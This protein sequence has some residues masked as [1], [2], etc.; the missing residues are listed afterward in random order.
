M[1]RERE[2]GD[3]PLAVCLNLSKLGRR[4]MPGKSTKFLIRVTASSRDRQLF[5]LFN[6]VT[7]TDAGNIARLQKYREKTEAG[8]QRPD[9]IDGSSN[10][11]ERTPRCRRPCCMLMDNRISVMLSR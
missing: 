8:G 4:S 11:W 9:E 1:E 2:K 3:R 5:H 6:D 10:G 7:A